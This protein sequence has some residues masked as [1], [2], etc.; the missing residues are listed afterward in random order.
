MKPICFL[1][2]LCCLLCGCGAA[3][4]PEFAPTVATYPPA[5]SAD[6]TLPEG[7][8]FADDT[9]ASIIRA[10]DNQVVGG[11]LDMQMNAESLEASTLD[12]AVGI[13][14]NSLG[15]VCE[16]ISMNADGY[17]A[18]SL[19]ITDPETEVRTETSRCL[20]PR[21]GSCYD[22]WLDIAST[23]DEERRAIEKSVLEE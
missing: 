11:I 13:Y 6:F 22:L 19:A 18:V 4:E 16:Y 10:A 15:P 8:A 5:A 2:A 9:T 1:L 20:F 7:Y 3:A 14:L 23:T 21:N 12:S 17:K